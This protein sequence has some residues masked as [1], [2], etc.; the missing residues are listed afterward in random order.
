METVVR[1]IYD[2]SFSDE[3][4]RLLLWILLNPEQVENNPK[5]KDKRDRFI[6][7]FKSSLEGRG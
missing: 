4:L 3:E 6:T 5:E 1:R 7:A 2:V